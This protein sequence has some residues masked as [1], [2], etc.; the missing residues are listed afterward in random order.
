MSAAKEGVDQA[1]TGDGALYFTRLISRASQS[2]L[3]RIISLP[4]YQSITIRN[5]NTTTKLLNMMDAARD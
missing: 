2:H 5:W 4:I 1:F 3:T